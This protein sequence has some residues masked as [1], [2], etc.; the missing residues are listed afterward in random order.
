MNVEKKYFFS[1]IALGLIVLGIVGAVAYGTNN[2]SN[3]GHT[4][5]E[6]YWGDKIDGNV[7]ADGFCIGTD[8]RTSWWT[9]GT[10]GTS[11]GS[12]TAG[13]TKIIAG[14]GVS[15]SSTNN[16]GT[17]DV[18]ITSTATGGSSQWTTSGS[19]IY[20]NNGKV[21]IGISTPTQK[22]EV[23]GDIKADSLCLGGAC[24]SSWPATGVTGC[25]IQ[26]TNTPNCVASYN[27]QSACSSGSIV[28]GAVVGVG[29]CQSGAAIYR[30][31]RVNCS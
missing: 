19:N 4:V 14:S 22:L 21:G 23:I 7:S 9:E 27:L 10:T 17:G 1:L 30:C 3:F 16:D 29:N 15:I 18:T 28:T 6:I 24:K 25:S 13:V 20:Y 5:G 26:C 2:P 12:T 31:C 11:G 8:C